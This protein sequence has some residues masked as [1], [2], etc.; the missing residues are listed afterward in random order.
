MDRVVPVPIP[1]NDFAALDMR[2][3]RIFYQT[4]PLQ[5]IEGALPG[6]KPAL[7]AYDLDKRR[8]ETI[9]EGLDSYSLSADGSHVL[10]KQGDD[11]SIAETKAGGGERHALHLDDMS[12][13]VLPPAEWSEMFNSAWRLERDFFYSEKTNGVNWQAVHDNYARL[14]P[15]LGSR[16]D[17]NYLI[18]QVQGELGN[19]HT[20]VGGGDDQ[21]PTPAAPTAL[22]GVDYALDAASGHYKFAHIYRGD[23]TRERYRSP[24]D[25]PGLNVHDDDTLLAVNGQALAAP[26]DPYSLFVDVHGPVM[27]TIS[28]GTGAARDILVDPVKTELPLREQDWIDHNRAIVDRL[29]GGR[30]AYIYLSDMESL[31]MEQFVRQFYPQMDKQALIVDDRWNGGGNID[32]ILLERLRRVLVGMSTNRERA[33]MTTP[34]QLIVG[35]KICLL[36][37]YS[38]SDG[39]IFPYYFRK[40]GL[41]PLLG[42]RSWG[43]VR[44]IRGN[45][46]LLDGGYITVPEDSLYGL[47]GQW[48]IENHG[49]DP[50][51]TLENEPGDLLAGHDR[52][53]E[54]AVGMMM[55]KLNHAAPHGQTPNAARPNLPQPPPLLPAYPP[56]EPG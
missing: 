13:R 2:G 7:H 45:W 17:L 53:L 23:D 50:D 11:Y 21:D 31:G 42:M 48:V 55:D 9:L 49:V 33:A 5:L 30:V 25:A 12:M 10:F 18:G 22:L 27:L 52:Q 51:I 43:G 56:G 26:M 16:E 29:S 37:Q 38:A 4:M 47:D 14:L 36:N 35:P 24:L 40:Y 28:S 44:G 6:E 8:D 32:Q 1:A 54:T 39:D 19:S 41:G 46:N 15:L 3:R 20:Y 34:Q